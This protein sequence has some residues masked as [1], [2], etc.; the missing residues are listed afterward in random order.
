MSDHNPKPSSIQLRGEGID[1]IN[2][3][4]QDGHLR[5]ILYNGEL[6]GS[7]IN[8]IQVLKPGIKNH[9]QYWKDHKRQL[10]AKDDGEI[11][12]E[13]VAN[14]YQLSLPASDG[15]MYKTD[16]APL[17]VCVYVAGKINQEFYKRM[18]AFTAYGI[19]YR[20]LNLASGKEWHADTVHAKMIEAN[21]EPVPDSELKWWQR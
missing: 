11:D 3:L 16:V 8:I 13:L 10:L 12:P 15:K 17:M 1:C 18:S 9:R 6:Y 4:I 14:L 7:L 20:F 5:T 2:N 19:K 21:L